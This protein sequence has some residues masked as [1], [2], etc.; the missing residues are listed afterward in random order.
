MGAYFPGPDDDD[1]G[2]DR[3]ELPL[4]QTR[5]QILSFTWRTLHEIK[6]FWQRNLVLTLRLAVEESDSVCVHGFRIA[7]QTALYPREYVISHKNIGPSR[8]NLASNIVDNPVNT[9]LGTP[10][11]VVNGFPRAQFTEA[12][13]A[14]IVDAQPAK[15]SRQS[16]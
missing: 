2:I 3:L 10:E 15:K 6:L 4:R 14:P 1:S 11:A 9:H 5:E 12:Q 16:N 7:D 13:R 8:L